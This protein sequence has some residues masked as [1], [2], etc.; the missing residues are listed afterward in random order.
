MEKMQEK[1]GTGTHHGSY[2]D[3]INLWLVTVSV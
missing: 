3:F 2:P 1:L